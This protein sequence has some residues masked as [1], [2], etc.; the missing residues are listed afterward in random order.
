MSISNVTLIEHDS[1]GASTTGGISPDDPDDPDDSASGSQSANSSKTNT[2]MWILKLKESFQ[3]TQTCVD[4]I[5]QHVSELCT[6][7]LSEVGEEVKIAL[8]AKKIEFKEVAGLQDLFTT[9]SPFSQP[10]SDLLTYQQ[11]L[12]FYN[13]NLKLIVSELLISFT[14]ILAV[15]IDNRIHFV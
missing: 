9:S 12:K 8:K 5:L 4:H 1:P 7:T 15:C 14:K 2:A 11:Q 3:L 6:V 13:N 10:F